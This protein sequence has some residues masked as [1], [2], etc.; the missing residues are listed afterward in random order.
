MSATQIAIAVVE[1][2][3]S[4]LIGRRGDDVPLA[5]MW[6]FPG[7]KIQVGETPHAAAARECLEETGIEVQP[8][9]TL[10]VV[11]HE[12]P[13]GP[14]ELHFVACRVRYETSPRAGFRWVPRGELNRYPFPAANRSLIECLLATE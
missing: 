7:G 5:G 14:L 12:Y 10:K 13:H 11:A 6:E 3:G 1:H 8:C 2:H 4:F 9:A